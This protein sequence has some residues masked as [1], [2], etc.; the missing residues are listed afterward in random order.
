[1]TGQQASG[2]VPMM[3]AD[4]VTAIN[5]A[6]NYRQG[7]IGAL[8]A[9]ASGQTSPQ[10]AWRSGVFGTV[11]VA[12]GVPLDLKAAQTASASQAVL[13]NPGNA[14]MSRAGSAAGPYLANWNASVTLG[15]DAN[16]TTNPRI[17]VVYAQIVDAALGDSG[18]Q[19][20]VINFVDGTPASSP[21]VPAIPTGAIPLAQISR[22]TFAAN[23]NSNNVTT[24]QITDVRKSA[25]TF[26]G[27]RNLLPGDGNADAGAYL[28]EVTNDTVT[29]LASGLRIWGT[30]AKWHGI[31]TR[32]FDQPTAASD[33]TH[34][35]LS[36][37]YNVGSLTIPDPG[38]AYRI[39]AVGECY[40]QNNAAN[41]TVVSGVD[42]LLIIGGTTYARARTALV[43]GGSY[44]GF[45]E[46]SLNSSPIV[47]GSQT[48]VFQ[49]LNPNA[50]AYIDVLP[51]SQWFSFHVSIIPT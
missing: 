17:D 40:V 34:L 11:S 13:V 30:D 23:G 20:A 51:T 46:V 5:S 48:I 39:S 16:P 35:G 32:C 33:S 37:T 1:M 7:F 25:C 50:T 29:S 27:V 24:A 41:P 18:T 19:G 10:Q 47:T 9:G 4:G 31:G 44:N 6:A 14:L 26:G 45:V 36:G 38:F 12:G 21:T 49:I 15:L 8:V 22:P 2:A 28:G 3:A 43:I 42:G